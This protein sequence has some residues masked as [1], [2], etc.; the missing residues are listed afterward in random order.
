[1]KCVCIPK[2]LPQLKK[3]FVPINSFKHIAAHCNTL[4]HTATHCN[5]LQHAAIHCTITKLTPIEKILNV[6]H[7]SAARCRTLQH[8]V[9]HGHTTQHTETPA[10][11]KTG[12]NGFEPLYQ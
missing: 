11:K 3:T 1:M 10:H 6:D 4:Q 9:T 8:T 7:H 5:T 2:T 12:S